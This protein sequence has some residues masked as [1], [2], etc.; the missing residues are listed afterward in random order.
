MLHHTKAKVIK[1]ICC[2]REVNSLLLENKLWI[3]IWLHIKRS[4]T[5]SF[6]QASTKAVNNQI[7]KVIY[8]YLI[9][10]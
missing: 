7:I 9:P 10:L 2:F 8:K 5:Y 3:V 4:V 1:N 6:L